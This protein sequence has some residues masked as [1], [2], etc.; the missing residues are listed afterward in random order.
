MRLDGRVALVVNGTHGAGP[1][2]VAALA[3]AGARVAATA[4]GGAET[5]DGAALV[6]DVGPADE[7]AVASFLDRC[8]RELGP[9]DVLVAS[10]RP[11]RSGPALDVTAA[12]LE[13][14]LLE[15]LV[16]PVVWITEVARRM[17]PRGRGR[18]VSLVSMSAKTGVH[19]GTAKY[20]AAKAGVMAFTRGL[21]AEI[22][23]S[24]VTVNAIAT[25]L[26]GPQVDAM[27]AGHRAEV[28]KGVPVGRFGRSEEAA[29]AVLYLAS[30]EAGYVTGETMSLSGGR[31]MD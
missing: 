1:A 6:A 30:D 9:V 27:P 20:A 23:A 4:P 22:A 7:R 24:G 17:V 3:G 11:V 13:R 14:V 12:E 25:A 5:P 21:A 16:D 2:I 26:L 28:L 10:A 29:H 31:F 15:E 18:I 19:T 8:E